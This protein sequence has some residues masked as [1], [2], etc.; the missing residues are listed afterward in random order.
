MEWRCLPPP[1]ATWYT[2][3][4]NLASIFRDGSVW[5]ARH[6]KYR[7]ESVKRKPEACACHDR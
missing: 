2:A 4:A 5:S 7:Q 1:E 3:R 6:R